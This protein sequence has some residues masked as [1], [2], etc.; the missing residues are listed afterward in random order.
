MTLRTL[1]L[2]AKAESAVD[3]T[4]A[5]FVA[6]LSQADFAGYFG[7][8][9]SLLPISHMRLSAHEI[10]LKSYL[11]REINCLFSKEIEKDRAD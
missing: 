1:P 5:D 2:M 4:Q 8:S 3:E 6:D 9:R 10:S 11:S 7:K